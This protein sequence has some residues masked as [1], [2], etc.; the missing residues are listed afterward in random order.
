M[1][2]GF[3]ILFIV[4]GLGASC[5]QFSQVDEVKKNWINEPTPYCI[6]SV[7]EIPGEKVTLKK[8]WVP[9]EVSEK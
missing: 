9:K 7:A 2:E 8:C 4:F 6:E 5:G 1:F 3:F